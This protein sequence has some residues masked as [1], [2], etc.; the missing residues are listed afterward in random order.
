MAGPQIICDTRQ[1]AKKHLNIDGWLEAHGIAYEYRKLDFGDYQRADGQGNVSVDSKKDV[2]ELAQNLGHDHSRFVRECVRAREA[3]FRLVILVEE[4]PEY[5]DRDKLKTWVSGVCR[6]CNHRMRGVCKGPS[7][8][9]G[10]RC[11]HGVKPMQ[12]QTVAAIAK[13][14]ESKYGV[15]FMFC[16]KRDTARIICDLLGIEVGDG[17]Q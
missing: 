7:T 2:Q 12:G 17:R 13:T 5:E 10:R 1:Q 3:G 15:R 8:Q 16:H 14:L 9:G 11:P 6:R 4:H